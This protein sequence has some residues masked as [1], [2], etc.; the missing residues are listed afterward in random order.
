MLNIPESIKILFKTDGVEKNFR[1]HFPNGE[2][3]D[4]TNENIVKESLR[5][6][7]SVC[8]QNVFRFG[9]AERSVLE[10]ETVGIG[11]MYGMT[12]EASIEIDTSSLTAA[13]ISTIQSGT[14]DGTL[15]LASASDIGYGFF[16]IPLGLFRVESCPRNHGAMTHRQVTAYTFH[17]TDNYI[18]SPYIKFL[19]N[20]VCSFAYSPQLLI[21]S[22]EVFLDSNIYW[23]DLAGLSTKYTRGANTE[24]KHNL[25]PGGTGSITNSNGALEYSITCRT[26]WLIN[27][28]GLVSYQLTSIEKNDYDNSAI[29]PW[30]E[31]QLETFGAQDLFP[32]FLK[33]AM[34]YTMPYIRH[35]QQ[36]PT[37]HD[38]FY[39]D[40]NNLVIDREVFQGYF[41][42]PTSVEITLRYTPSGGATSSV[43]KTFTVS[44]SGDGYQ[45][46]NYSK[47][48]I[49]HQ[50]R[51]IIE[52][53][54]QNGVKFTYFN[55][56]RVLELYGAFAEL[57]GK[58]AREDRFGEITMIE[59]SASS[60]I[61][62][63][64]EDYSSAWW[65]EYDIAPIGTVLA[66][67]GEDGSREA[68]EV[69]IGIG[70][71]VYDMTDNK[72]IPMSPDINAG[73]LP[74][75]LSREFA[76]G[77]ANVGYTP[78]ELEMQGWPWIEA[79][80]AL[81]ITAEDGSVVNT[82]AMR[83]EMRGIQHLVSTITSPSGEIVEE[84]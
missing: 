14:W 32:A 80:D 78:V 55:A 47:I 30:V 15:V 21:P 12:I 40:Y 8:S 74:D 46:F 72:M 68:E 59:L 83:I 48:D 65:D 51:I 67:Y 63:L 60:P 41:Y 20:G 26:G 10:F 33:E 16:R 76:A 1:A 70:E 27:L 3:A 84:A 5:F 54:T 66:S 37:T 58:F 7:E 34:K 75:V 62:I 56:F 11:N 13:E 38:Y 44:A 28:T 35:G 42:S 49:S 31:A 57:N 45:V 9:C 6:T 50:Y 71:S 53:A 4:I 64:P 82:Y 43:T 79:G 61:A 18:T 36:L 25:N 19:Q 22:V 17:L 2:F 24:T 81:Q 23:N 52:A 39:F 69:S 73:T 77:A 29:A